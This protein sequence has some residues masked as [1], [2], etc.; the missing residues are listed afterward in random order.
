M[1]DLSIG[2]ED[3]TETCGVQI[4]FK[5]TMSL[6]SNIIGGQREVE[7]RIKAALDSKW[8]YV[9]LIS[10]DGDLIVVKLADI[11]FYM[12]KATEITLNQRIVLPK[13]PPMKN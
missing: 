9:N 5:S 13:D 7:Q 11:S 6:S 3:T 2:K 12:V 4:A 1:T 8:P 10:V